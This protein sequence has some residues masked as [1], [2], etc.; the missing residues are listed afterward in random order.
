MLTEHFGQSLLAQF[1]NFQQSCVF[2]SMGFI[3][4]RRAAC[5]VVFTPHYTARTEAD[6]LAHDTLSGRAD[7][8]NTNAR[9]H[10]V[11][12]FA[13]AVTDCRAGAARAFAP[14]L[15]SGGPIAGHRPCASCH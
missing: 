7:P 5:F 13:F 15:Q 12:D 8:R 6:Y 11:V 4:P 9:P 2:E 10:A 14:G 1:D 3:R